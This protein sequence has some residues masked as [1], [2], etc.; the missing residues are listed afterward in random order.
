[1]LEI[2]LVEAEL[3]HRA[4]AL[5]AIPA[6]GAEDAADVEENVRQSQRSVTER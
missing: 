5:F 1:M 6:I 2:V 3:L 4:S